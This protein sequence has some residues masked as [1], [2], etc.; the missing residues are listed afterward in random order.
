[1]RLGAAVLQRPDQRRPAEEIVRKLGKA[2][3]IGMQAG[4]DFLPDPPHRRVVVAEELGLDLLLMRRAILLHGAHERHLAT[5]VLSEQ[6]VGLEEIVLVV[7]LQHTDT[8]RLGERSEMHRR[9][10]DRRRDVHELQIEVPGRQHQTPDV[11]HERNVR[12]VD[13]HR[14]LHLIV[15]RG[16]VLPAAVRGRSIRG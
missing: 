14:Q 8:R 1:M 13:G 2:D 15:E 10:I 3:V 6:L 4:D 7:L 12:V 9:R 5:D 16:H 11:A